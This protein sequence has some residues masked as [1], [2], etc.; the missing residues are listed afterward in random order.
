[1][2]HEI[3]ATDRFGE[4]RKNGQRAWHGLGQE[5]EDG[6]SAQEAFKEIGLGWST[7]LAPVTA[8]VSTMGPDGPSTIQVPL[9]G[10]NPPM[11][12]MRIGEGGDDHQL[13]G[14]VTD[15]YKPFENMDLA[16]FADGLVDAGNVSIETAGSLYNGRRVFALVKLSE[17]IRAKGDDIME[18]YILVQNGHGGTAALA[19]YPTAVRVVCANTL[20][21]SESSMA[22]GIKFQHTGR[23]D[24]KLK[25][26]KTVLNVAQRESHVFQEQVTAL[27][28]R[29]LTAQETKDLLVE[30]YERTFGKMPDEFQVTGE[31][32]E[33]LL[34]KRTNLIE[35]WEVNLA[36]SRQQISG[37][38]GTAWSLY[39]AISEYHD[40]DRGRFGPIED[41]PARV[42]SN[43]FGVS[44]RAK[45]VAFSTLL[46]AV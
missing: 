15:G 8:Q 4:V 30:V 28:G 10:Q 44:H 27:V 36:N 5:I 7:T 26:A 11:A 43:I 39:N 17:V 45:K 22:K 34:I 24:E 12:H 29:N 33:K 35:Q 16:R 25:Q 3:H 46:G 18:Q 19:C 42:G 6:L 2:A 41:S 9:L 38:G 37:I 32:R 13:L 20:R 31:V 1:M 14:M 23:F 40:H 21:W